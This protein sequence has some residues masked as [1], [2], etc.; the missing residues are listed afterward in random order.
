MKRGYKPLEKCR[1]GHSM[2]ET[3]EVCSNGK[4]RC[5]VCRKSKA[6]NYVPSA[7][8]RWI[9][10]A[11]YKF[12]I[13]GAD[14]Q[15]LIRTFDGKCGICKTSNFGTPNPVIDHDHSTGK[16]RGILCRTCNLGIGM[17]VDSVEV[18]E[19]AIAYLKR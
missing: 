19:S 17:F 8:K 15:E 1:Q 13:G 11:R 3:R 9:S 16:I 5:S 4:T 12:G 14:L 10:D 7:E 6:R 2:L 18:L